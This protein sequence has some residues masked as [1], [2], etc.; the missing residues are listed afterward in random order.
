M[1][2]F[3]LEI[4]Q[5]LYRNTSYLTPETTLVFPNRRAG[6]FFQKY[7]STLV[8]RPIF[9]PE[10]STISDLVSRFAQLKVIDPVSGVIYLYN[11]YR[12]ITGSTESLDE[13]FFWG[14]MMLSDFNDI[15]KYG[16]DAHK[17]FQN[18]ESLKEI[19]AGFDFLTDE[20]RKFL[21]SFWENLIASRSSNDKLVFLEFWKRL[22]PIYKSFNEQLGAMGLASEGMVYRKAVELIH[23]P[24]YVPDTRK[25]VLIG[26][27]A[28]NTCEKEI[29][30]F[31]KV[32]HNAL[33][34]WDFDT[35]YMDKAHHEA[36]MF[37]NENLKAF[38]M[39]DDFTPNF[40]NFEQVHSIQAVAVP[41]FMGQ[42][43]YAG[44]W[45][46]ENHNS[47]HEE[48]DHTAVVLCD[49]N[50]LLPVMNG[51]PDVVE[52]MN[53]TMG[54]PL[55]DS[56]VFSLIK[57]IVDLDRNARI[58][59]DGY[60]FYFRT[61]L[62]V[63][64]HSL[65]KPHLAEL[66]A[67]LELRIKRMNRIY[68]KPE[69]FE[70]SELARLVFR[71]PD[72]IAG[73]KLYLQELLLSLF[74]RVSSDD[75][76]VKECIYQSYLAV[77]RLNSVLET[78]ATD[79]QISKKLYYQVLLRA[80][81]R[82]S[83]P[84]EGE[85]LS[86]LQIMGF[87]ETRCLD[88]DRLVLLSV[89]DTRLPGS[90]AGHSFI[91]YSLRR[92]FGL[93]LLEQRN[94]MYA[95][96]FYRLLQRAKEV[97]LVYDSRTEA[98]GG[99]E[100]SRFVTQLKYEA[101]FANI[102]FV[103]G[104][105]SFSPLPEKSIQVEKTKPI[106]DGLVEFMTRPGGPISPSALSVYLQ[107]TLRFYFRYIEK[108][109]EADD[110]SEE[111]DQMMFGR[112][113]HKALEEIY[114]SKVG[115]IV[116]SEWIDSVLKNELLLNKCLGKALQE[117]YFKGGTADIS[118]KNLLVYDIIK[119]YL[120]RILKYDRSI[121][122]FKL[123]SLEEQYE[124]TVEVA[125][126]ETKSIDVRIGGIV[127]RLDE[128]DGSIRVVDYKTGKTDGAITKLEN[129]FKQGLGYNKPAFQTL[130]YAMAVS[131]SMPDFT[132][133]KPAVYGARAVFSDSFSPLFRFGNED[134]TYNAVEQEFGALLNQLLTDI[135]DPTIPFRQVADAQKCAFCPYRTICNR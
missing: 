53:V 112:I 103:Q 130:L 8:E 29:F 129:L 46:A 41:G 119:K 126:S 122:P 36:A 40:S 39:P 34:F 50:L 28:L 102:Q 22:F 118:G 115:Q 89:N 47:N 1:N 77:T 67:D 131:R 58:S 9:S 78:S 98:L 79:Q 55:K 109:Q 133:V 16:A 75:T 17:L 10:I 64:N 108:V 84:F 48:F 72:D 66:I 123:L 33:F 4:A 120:V 61:V 19:D 74:E 85:P 107:C 12:E 100:V 31:L 23:N 3:L 68:L 116:E 71:L 88:F 57:S 6:L 15:D 69:D 83:I 7:L 97:V 63:L 32:N 99:G 76:I 94:A 132:T 113:A 49:E 2:K 60:T 92:G 14:E 96:Y 104:K 86:G 43:S 135:F 51:I 52:N 95:Y 30:K 20:Q 18:I 93:P 56:P 62:N 35:Y 27:N 117:E 26:F 70:S 91:P 59:P 54:Y 13:F 73:C 44:Q 65:L 127:D 38:P 124:T 90:T 134:L 111:I 110:V 128:L 81:E 25:Y 125:V 82:L 24:N 80:L 21:S 37:M 87:L 101:P 114:G 106:Y 121:A 42:A 11:V 5:Y 105:F 45:L